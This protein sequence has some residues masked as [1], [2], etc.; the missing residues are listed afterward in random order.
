[1][2]RTCGSHRSDSQGNI[3]DVPLTSARTGLLE[4]AVSLTCGPPGTHIGSDKKH[5]NQ[6]PAS[7]S[8]RKNTVVNR[9]MRGR[10][11]SL[12]FA[13][14]RVWLLRL[15]RP[16]YLGLL[17]RFAAWVRSRLETRN[18]KAGSAQVFAG[19]IAQGPADL[20]ACAL[21]VVGC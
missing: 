14:V 19:G 11:S 3:V 5:F 6:H 20:F 2:S 7:V 17:G 1:M 4:R 21:H 13:M 15:R 12:I 18:G 9:G 10:T 16:D 8:I